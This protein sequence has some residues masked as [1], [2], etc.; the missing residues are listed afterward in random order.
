[1]K[2]LNTFEFYRLGSILASYTG[3][4]PKESLKMLKL[5]FWTRELR[6][7]LKAH[8]QDG[9]ASAGSKRA[10]MGL[11]RAIQEAG[12]PDELPTD[13]ADWDKPEVNVDIQPWKLSLIATKAKELEK[14][15]ANDLPGL[16]TY[17]VI[18]KGLFSTDDLI[19]HAD[20]HI[21]ESLRSQLP[22]QAQ[23]DINEA[24][25]CLAFELPTASAFHIWRATETTMDE[26]YK[27]LSGGNSFS[28]DKVQRTWDSYVKALG[29][30]GA[31]T[32]VTAF[33]DHIRQEYRNPVSH[34]SVNIEMEEAFSLFGAALSVVTQTLRMIK[35]GPKLSRPAK[36]RLLITPEKE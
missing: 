21:P 33:L 5:F 29:T 26:Y 35:H 13:F 22:P 7:I 8:S 6:T 4:E 9:L 20:I 1:V 14:V 19:A 12:C 15:L 3:W 18:Q 17:Y 10:I 23:A 28:D 25:R 2:K 31:E 24:G 34:P 16:A 36:T 30:K 11:L 27:M 32:K